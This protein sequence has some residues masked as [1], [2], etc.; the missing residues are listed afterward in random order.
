[1]PR[2]FAVRSEFGPAE[3]T[4]GDAGPPSRSVRTNRVPSVS[5]LITTSPAPRVA[6]SSSTAPRASVIPPAGGGTQFA[7]LGR[8][9][10]ALP[11]ADKA[12]IAGLRAVHSWELS[13]INCAGRPA[14]EEQKR[15]RPPVEHPLVR[16]HP[17]T[18]AKGLYLGNHAEIGRAHV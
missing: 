15:E 12:R 13:R 16:T 5:M 2:S 17:D 3:I 9:Y 6:A 14:T 11:D 4:F 10:A 18:G 8:A 7:H 1:M